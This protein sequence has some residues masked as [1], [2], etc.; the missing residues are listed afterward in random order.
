[1]GIA[2]LTEPSRQVELL[3]KLIS[4][5]PGERT[6]RRRLIRVHLRNGD[7][8]EADQAI[9]AST[10]EIGP[11]NIVER[12]KGISAI[13][14]AELTPGLMI[15]DRVAMLLEAERIALLCIKNQSSDRHNYRLL[16]DVGVA[17]ARINGDTRILEESVEKF[18]DIENSISDPDFARERRDYESRLR[19]LAMGSV[20]AAPANANLLANSDGFVDSEG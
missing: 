14:R 6:P 11:D 19:R 7:L 3:S 4:I 13:Q 12:Y 5:V 16:A 9:A 18:K 10:R 2:R 20:D 15:E 8:A 17:L 1:M